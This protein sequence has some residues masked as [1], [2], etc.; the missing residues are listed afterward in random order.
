MKFIIWEWH[1]I[2]PNIILSN[3]VA[4]SMCC[5]SYITSHMLLLYA[6]IPYMAQIF[7]QGKPWRIW[8]IT[9]ALSNFTVQFL[10]CLMTYIN[11]ES[12]QTGIYQS[13]L[14]Q[15][16]TLYGNLCNKVWNKLAIVKILRSFI[17][18]KKHILVRLM[19]S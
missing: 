7:G 11:K 10:Q 8:W 2:I 1:Y 14:H 13:F 16:F 15:K 9:G 12:K 6:H 19:G 4:P 18:I 5:N 3:W 17:N